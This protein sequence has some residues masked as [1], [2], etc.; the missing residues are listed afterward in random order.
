MRRRERFE[1]DV[2]QVHVL[3]VQLLLKLDDDLDAAAV[4]S[5]FGQTVQARES[6]KS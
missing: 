4:T 5:G 2:R 1:A 3:F 6:S